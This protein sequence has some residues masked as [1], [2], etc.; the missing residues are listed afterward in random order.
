[1]RRRLALIVLAVTG[2]I[3]V[4]FLLPLAAVVRV[5]AADRALSGA[6]QEARSLAGVLSAITDE[7][8]L[9]AVVDDLNAGSARS[10]A[11]FLPD[12]SR[13]GAVI[14]VSP[15][16]LARARS[17]TAFTTSP[18]GAR[19]VWVPVR[20]ANG[21]VTVAVVEAPAGL[22]R[23]AACTPRGPSWR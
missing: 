12:G 14:N 19:R 16:D 11:V 1:M 10:A 20:S 18:G 4:A 5:V 21:S 3:T 6:D 23:E 15:Q 7:P 13:I 2:M 8:S 9:T 17:G 22:V